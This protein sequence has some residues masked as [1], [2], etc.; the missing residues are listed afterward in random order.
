M[1][2]PKPRMAPGRSSVI[3][4]KL[5]WHSVIVFIGLG[6]LSIRRR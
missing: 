4:V 3:R 6:T 1:A 5:P 2:L